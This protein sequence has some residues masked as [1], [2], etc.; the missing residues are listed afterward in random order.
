VALSEASREVT[1][2]IDEQGETVP[3]RLLKPEDWDGANL[4]PVPAIE[5][6]RRMHLHEV[7]VRLHA[8]VTQFASQ[9]PRQVGGNGGAQRRYVANQPRQPVADYLVVLREALYRVR[10]RHLR[11]RWRRPPFVEHPFNPIVPARELDE[12]VTLKVRL[13]VSRG[14][15]A[16]RVGE[17]DQPLD[18]GPLVRVANASAH[19]SFHGSR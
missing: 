1:T 15:R 5:D 18:K 4:E 19:G 12:C 17:G 10:V 7:A 11:L 14:A 16:R 2:T 3:V 6:E 9:Y 13:D 8:S